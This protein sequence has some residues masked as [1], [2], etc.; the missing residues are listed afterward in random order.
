MRLRLLERVA[1][2]AEGPAKIDLDRREALI[3]SLTEHLTAV[4]SA[5]PSAAK[6]PDRYGLPDIMAVYGSEG[7]R[8]LEKTLTEVIKKFE[9]RLQN[10]QV[11]SQASQLGQ[12]AFAITGTLDPAG[13][14]SLVLTA[15][16]DS[17]GQIRVIR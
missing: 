10:P 15:Y 16:L 7:L 4:L 9:P 13:P 2:L 5:R 17:D 3:R 12:L 11:T 14:Q 1:L 8:D 6:A